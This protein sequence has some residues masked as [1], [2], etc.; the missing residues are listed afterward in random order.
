VVDDL[1]GYR[2]LLVTRPEEITGWVA[3]S[4][5]FLTTHYRD[6]LDYLRAYCNVGTIGG[7]ILLYRFDEPPTQAPGPSAPAG[8]CDGP[9]SR[10]M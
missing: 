4:A 6:Q 8:R 3:V 2:P 1:P 7:T 5:T 9:F 10:R